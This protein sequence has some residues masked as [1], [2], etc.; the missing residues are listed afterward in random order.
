LKFYN[1]T[2][3][4]PEHGK[5]DGLKNIPP[6][7]NLPKLRMLYGYDFYPN[8]EDPLA[9]PAD[10]VIDALAIDTLTDEIVCI[11][12]E[13]WVRFK[14]YNRE[15]D[16][17]Y[18]AG[19]QQQYRDKA[20]TVEEW[21]QYTVDS[22]IY[23]INRFRAIN[24]YSKLGWWGMPGLNNGKPIW[25]EPDWNYRGPERTTQAYPDPPYKGALG[26]SVYFG[27]Q[28]KDYLDYGITAA[29]W[30]KERYIP[31]EYDLYTEK[32]W[33]DSLRHS[34]AACDIGLDKPLLAFFKPTKVPPKTSVPGEMSYYEPE[35]LDYMVDGCN[36]LMESDDVIALWEGSRRNLD[37]LDI[38]LANYA[39][40][41]WITRMG[42]WFATGA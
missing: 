33:F 31:P 35:L 11:D 29:Y 26:T 19:W 5:F 27:E 14:P 28:L 40:H 3:G 30:Q 38:D 21:N 18:K 16:N 9:L 37:T 41:Y 17:Y 7:W 36:R 39:D 24:T 8:G 15:W 6:E 32:T 1:A 13:G 10:S 42:Q 12:I 4:R 20:A 34:K 22:Q 2:Q 23:L 25:S